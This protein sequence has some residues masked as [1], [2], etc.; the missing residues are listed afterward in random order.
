MRTLTTAIRLTLP[1]AT[2]LI[3][4]L[5]V[6]AP[7]PAAPAPIAGARRSVDAVAFGAVEVPAQ[8]GST[9]LILP[10]CEQLQETG[11][12]RGAFRRF[13]YDADAGACHLFIYGGCG[14]NENNFRTLGACRRVCVSRR[15]C[16]L[17][18]KPGP[19]R[20]RFFR[21]WYNRHTG[22]CEEFVYGGCGGNANNFSSREACERRCT[23]SASQNARHPRHAQQ[24]PGD[25]ERR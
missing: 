3:A 5:A 12:C 16:R 17:P 11:P 25:D 13:W 4:A 23:D 20:A 24:P 15:M 6:T 9:E 19:C 10:R 21:W 8:V 1:A 18:M 22:R 14:G 2:A 7:T